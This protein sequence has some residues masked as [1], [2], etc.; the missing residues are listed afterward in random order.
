MSIDML[1]HVLLHHE[2]HQSVYCCSLLVTLTLYSLLHH[3]DDVV[4]SYDSNDPLPRPE[5]E[6]TSRGGVTIF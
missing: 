6:I 4:R 1:I 2:G 5:R 3:G